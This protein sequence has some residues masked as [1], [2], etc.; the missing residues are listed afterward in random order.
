[1]GFPNSASGPAGVGMPDSAPPIT[2]AE[3]DVGGVEAAP[4]DATMSAVRGGGH[5]AVDVVSPG[6]RSGGHGLV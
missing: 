6:T 2:R 1:V 3:A 5:K 4:L